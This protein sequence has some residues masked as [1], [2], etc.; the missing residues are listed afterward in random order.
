[1][2][3]INLVMATT[4]PIIKGKC[5][6]N[7]PAQKSDKLCAEIGNLGSKADREEVR[8]I[9]D[10]IRG[11]PRNPKSASNIWQD[12][13]IQGIDKV[14][15]ETIVE[16][17]PSKSTA[18]DKPKQHGINECLLYGRYTCPAMCL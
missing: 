1:M 3:C 12:C 14:N 13:H 4:C 6:M 18:D 9:W 11:T 15:K 16:Q 8:A 2:H 10:I 17:R 7:E 5:K